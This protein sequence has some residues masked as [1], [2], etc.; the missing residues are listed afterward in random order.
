MVDGFDEIGRIYVHN[1][2][3]IP[4]FAAFQYEEKNGTKISD[5]FKKVS[6]YGKDYLSPYAMNVPKDSNISLFVR[7]K[8]MKKNYDV[9]AS[10]TFLFNDESSKVALYNV[11][12]NPENRLLQFKGVETLKWENWSQ[13]ITYKIPDGTYF[14]PHNKEELKAILLQAARSGTTVR[15]SG[16]RHSQPPLTAPTS[17]DS[18]NNGP[19]T[20]MIDLACYKDL[21]TE[22]IVIDDAN[23]NQVIVNAGIREDE[24]CSFLSERNLILRTVTA[25]GFFSLGG[26]TS[27]DVHGST[28]KEGIF[29]ETAVAFTI[30]G[31]DGET[32]TINA[33]T[34]PMDG[35][36]I[37]PLNFARVNLGALGIVTR[38]TLSVL[39]RPYP[40]SLRPDI[41][42]FYMNDAP[43][44]ACHMSK[45]LAN[46]DRIEVFFNPHK[47][48]AVSL[49]WSLSTSDDTFV[50]KIDIMELETSTTCTDADSNKYGA[51]D[52]YESFQK[53]L[54]LAQKNKDAAEFSVHEALEKIKKMFHE[55][56][57]G[58]SDLWLSDATRC[59]FMSYFV[60]LPGTS[61][62]ESISTEALKFA[63]GGL[64]AVVKMSQSKKTG[65]EKF[66]LAAPLEFRF[67]H[68]GKT[69]LAATY[70]ENNSDGS[71]FINF[72]MIAFVKA[73]DSKEY[74]EDLQNFFAKIEKVWLLEM[75][76]I[77]HGG[78]MYGF[79]DPVTEKLST[80]KGAFN[81]N[82][83]KHLAALRESRIGEFEKFRSSRDKHGM[84]LNDHVRKILGTF[85][86]SD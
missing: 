13:N 1:E 69:A 27:M 43:S 16:Q 9:V 76:G 82:F 57:K 4:F 54:R 55:S 51:P 68:S 42:G 10:E 31:P 75:N 59:M 29:S 85:D 58:H 52:S 12:S 39:P 81:D 22:A 36:S 77:P 49:L 72:D 78:K 26:M 86:Y 3:F 61:G 79:V 5:P 64:D 18:E 33:S 70:K 6:D 32:S 2:T 74:D 60:P 45:L 63:W 46:Y 28:V 24:L 80:Q 84:F 20:I 34:L 19:G 15:V 50:D 37:R 38:I 67:V 71:H 40:D 35:S 44:F 53:L 7:S 65:G 23:P 73:V 62:D 14:Y 8:G 21:G 30:M 48:Y 17:A 11:S 83:M 25:G 56:T 41:R 66:F 47:S